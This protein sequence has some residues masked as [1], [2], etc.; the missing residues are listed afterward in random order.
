MIIATISVQKADNE[1]RMLDV[2]EEGEEAM[3]GV[4]YPG[5]AVSSGNKRNEL[6]CIEVVED[7][8]IRNA[9]G[10]PAAENLLAFG[11]G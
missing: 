2:D 8:A 11:V 5:P 7:V 10:T 3:S 9:L 1:Q 4:C 6:V